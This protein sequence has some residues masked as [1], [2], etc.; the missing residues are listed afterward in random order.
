MLIGMKL[1]FHHDGFGTMEEWGFDHFHIDPEYVTEPNFTWKNTGDRTIEITHRGERRIVNYDFQ[2]STSDYGLKQ[3]RMF[4]IRKKVSESEDVGFWVSP[5][6]LV[7][8]PTDFTAIRR[9]WN[10]IQHK[11]NK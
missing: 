3:L 2:I 9:I 10:W 5:F 6:S 11:M 1:A 7:Y 4:E 8:N